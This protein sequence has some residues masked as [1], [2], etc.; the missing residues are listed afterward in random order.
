[1]QK[2]LSKATTE[3]FKV[4]SVYEKFYPVTYK[5]EDL[6][7]NPVEGTFYI[8][9]QVRARDTGVYFVKIIKIRKINGVIKYLVSWPEYP[10]AGTEWKSKKELMK[11]F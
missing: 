11:I 1:M 4:E 2:V 6:E 7:G 3:L 8:Q 10:E 9:E 5:V